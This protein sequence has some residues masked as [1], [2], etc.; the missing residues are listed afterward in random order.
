MAAIS[1]VTPAQHD[2]TTPVETSWRAWIVCLIAALFFF[3]EFIQMNMLSS[4][5]QDLMAAFDVDATRLGILSSTYFYANVIFL[6]PAGQLLD[7]YSTRTIILIALSLC[8][9][10]TYLFSLTDSLWIAAFFRFVTGI[11]SAF[12]FLSSIRLASRWFPANHMALISGLIVTMAMLG[13]WVIAAWCYKLQATWQGTVA[14][15]DI[16]TV[17]SMSTP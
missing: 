6:L 4:L 1:C 2:S 7:R 16:G 5:N 9:L 17:S 12:C 3:Y 13:G 15:A 10:G 8:V 14:I 11:G